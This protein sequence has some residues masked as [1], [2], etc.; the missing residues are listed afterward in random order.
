M[1]GLSDITTASAYKC[2]FK[3]WA[4]CNASYDGDVIASYNFC[5]MACFLSKLFLSLQNIICKNDFYFNFY[6]EG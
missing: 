2:H 5:V 1:M 4:C 6:A 3:D